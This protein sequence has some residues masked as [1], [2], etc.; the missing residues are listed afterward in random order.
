V[1]SAQVARPPGPRSRI[2]GRLELRFLR[3]PPGFLRD[4]ATYGELAHFRFRSTDVYLV[5]SPESIKRVLAADHRGFVKGQ[6]M[7]ESKRVLGE[8]LLTSEGHLHHRQR[9]LLQ[10][11][12]H[13]RRVADYSATMV[14]VIERATTS[15]EAGQ[16]RDVHREMSELTIRVVSETLFSTDLER[17]AGEIVEALGFAVSMI[18]RL[19]LPG[20]QLWERLP[21]PSSRRFARAL[22]RL[23]RATEEILE[24]RRAN[25]GDGDD[26]LA[27]LLAA[28]AEG[29]GAGLSDRQVRDETITLLLAGHETT[30]NLLSWTWFLLS[31][32]PEVES[33]L[34]DE[35]DDVLGGRVPTVDDLPRLVYTGMILNEAMRLYPPVWAM[36]RRA[37]HDYELDGYTI[38]AGSVVALNAYVMHHDPRFYPDPFRFDPE[39]WSDDERRKRPKYAYFPFGGGPRV[40]LGEGFA[41]TEARLVLATLAQRWRLRLAQGHRVIAAPVLT[42]RPEHGLRMVLEARAGRSRRLPATNGR[43]PYWDAA[44]EVWRQGREQ[45]LW[46]RHSDAVN[47]ALVERW[48]PGR[49]RRLLKTDLWDEAVGDGLV[50]ALTDRADE[51]VGID[52][53]GSV[54]EA[55]RSRHPRLTAVRADVRRLPFEDASFDAV[56]SNSTLDHFDSATDIAAALRELHRVLR[57]GGTLVLTLDNPENPLVAAARALPRSWLNRAWLRYGRVTARIGLLPYY[58]G[59]TVD[60]D[61]LSAM[62]AGVGFEVRE[63]TAIVHSPRIV[64][65]LAGA[66]VER[67][68][69]PRARER[70]LRLLLGFEGLGGKRIRFRT[71]HFVAVRAARL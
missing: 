65:S 47:A 63:R 44:A 55:A 31:Q 38:P 19:T 71:G 22:A 9:R 14:D 35:L 49:A 32:H 60:A 18:G 66:L 17:D 6:S 10:P 7:Q 8:G 12:F 43:E 51:T 69:S 25:G 20:A 16:T 1:P 67:H 46:R 59:A 50:A 21:F 30:A 40:C 34:H 5:T 42:L 64:A 2:P 29:N 68:G 52:V 45:I 54:I 58:V 61:R 39:R 3:D 15:W 4:L 13:A 36:G 28:Q 53:S 37:I 33:R 70:F 11:A 23:D 56:V 41:W 48:L 26:V 24:R 27:L 62:L 57:S